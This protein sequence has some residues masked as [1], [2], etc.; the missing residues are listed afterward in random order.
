MALITLSR[1]R[2]VSLHAFVNGDKTA[3]ILNAKVLVPFAGGGPDS[4]RSIPIPQ[5]PFFGSQTF[6]LAL[7][8]AGTITTLTYG[9]ESGAAAGLNSFNAVMA[10]FAPRSAA[11]KAAEIQARAD[12][13]AQ[14]QRLAVCEAAPKD[15][16]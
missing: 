4:E 8:D 2:Q 5:A 1:I 13:I 6:V 7:S 14:T 9:K 16:K 10:A 15:C 11:D 12:L 3:D